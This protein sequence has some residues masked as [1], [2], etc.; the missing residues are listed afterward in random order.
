MAVNLKLEKISYLFNVG[1]VCQTFQSRL[2]VFPFKVL[3]IAETP[4]IF[5]FMKGGKCALLSSIS[6]EPY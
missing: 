5:T 2:M 1:Q 3:P 4:F 6:H